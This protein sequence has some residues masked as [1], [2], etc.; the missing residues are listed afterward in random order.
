[1]VILGLSGRNFLAKMFSL[2]P[3]L[4]VGEASYCL[5]ILHF[6]LWNIIHD[7]RV[8]ERT[9]LVRFDPWLSYTVLVLAALATMRW[10]ERPG[11][12]WIKRMLHFEPQVQVPTTTP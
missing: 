8:L 6:N 12:R 1:M 7:S 9:G 3:L 11:Q 2:M 5:Y 4:A 10:I